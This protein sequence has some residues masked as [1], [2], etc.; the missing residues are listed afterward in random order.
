[1]GDKFSAVQQNFV[2]VCVCVHVCL[3]AQS[4][5]TL[6]DPIDCSLAGSTVHGILQARILEWAAMG[7]DGKSIIPVLS[8]AQLCKAT[9][10]CGTLEI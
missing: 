5:A 4:C 7:D 3:V 9:Y 8:I 1:M 2:C 10:G 6:C